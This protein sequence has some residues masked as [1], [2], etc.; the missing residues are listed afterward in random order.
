MEPQPLLR[1]GLWRPRPPGDPPR[2]GAREGPRPFPLGCRVA[3]IVSRVLVRSPSTVVVSRSTFRRR[4]PP[5]RK[6]RSADPAAAGLRRL[7]LAVT[8]L[9]PISIVTALLYYYGYVTAYAE[10]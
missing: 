4:P 9:G 3:L 7:R 8:V 5:P 1:R 6:D 10:Y 2:R